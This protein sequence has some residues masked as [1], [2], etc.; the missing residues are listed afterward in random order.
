[1]GGGGGGKKT[2]IDIT[3]RHLLSYRCFDMIWQE[4]FLL[5]IFVHK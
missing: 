3:A 2:I 1:M 5:T 4:L